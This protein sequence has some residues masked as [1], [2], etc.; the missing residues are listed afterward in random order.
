MSD[1]KY[2]FAKLGEQIGISL[3]K[4]AKDQLTEAENLVASV[5]V[6]VE[7][8]NAQIAE[9]EKL[10]NDMDARLHTFGESVLEAHKK[11]LNGKGA[12]GEQR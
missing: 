12:A 1:H 4:A 3:L 9:Q 2:S 11:F 8:I 6:L 5:S 10:L 7:G